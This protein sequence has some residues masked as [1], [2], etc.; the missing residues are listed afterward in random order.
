M[1]LDLERLT[2]FS[3]TIAGER[4]QKLKTLQKI[5]MRRKTKRIITMRREEEE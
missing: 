2:N 1:G 5:C 4:T 3:Q